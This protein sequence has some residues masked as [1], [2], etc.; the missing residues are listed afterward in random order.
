MN[1][2]VLTIYTDGAARGNPGPAAWAIV[3]R[4]PDD[5]EEEH[6][7]ALGEAT[8]NV[9]EYAA[10][11]HA[12]ERA[13]QLGSKQVA[14]HSDSELMVKQMRGEYR[15]KNADLQ[16]LY[17]EAKELERQLG[18]VTYTHVRREQNS[19]ADKL[20][21]IVLDGTG[22]GKTAGAGKKKAPAASV[23]KQD[24]ARADALACLRGVETAW[25][26]AAPR[27]PTAEQVWDQLWSIL[28]EHGLVRGAK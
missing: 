23:E 27:A 15:V 19:H 12:L 17:Q 3:V 11:V 16:D 18:R 4:K 7:G 8:N 28:E 25:K 6:S 5:S 13:V 10:L 1:A 24:G 20:C 21:N 2:P 26:Q 14:I 22:G 9:A